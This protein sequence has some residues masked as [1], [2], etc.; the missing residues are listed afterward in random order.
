MVEQKW[1]ALSNTTLGQLVAT[2]NTS[3]II[4]ALPPVFRGIH[5]NP[6][7]PDSFPY[8]LWIIMS[9]MIVVSV[10]LLTIG[11]L[12]DIFGRVRLFNLGFLIFTMGSILLYLT[13]NTADIGALEIILF[14]II[15][16]VGGSFIMANSFAL[17]TDNFKES[18]RGFA[19]S[20]NSLASV[21]G[22]S[23]GIVVGGV[24]SVIYWRD[25][26]LLSVPLGIFGTAWSYLKLK[27]TSPRKKQKIDVLGNVLMAAG[28]ISLLIGVTYGITPYK[29]SPMGWTN[30]MV[31]LALIIGTLLI[32]FFI[33]WEGRIESPM[34][35]I[36]LFRNRTFAIG[37]FTAFI[38]AMGMMGLLYMLT[39]L[40]Q[41]V[42]LPLH[43]YSFSITPLWAGIYMLP[44]TV[45]MGIFGIIAG[46]LADR[47]GAKWLV[48]FGLLLSGV[49]LFILS[50]LSYNFLYYKMMILLILFGIGYA[51]FNSPNI[52][53]VMSTVPP[54]ER[55]SASGTL[56]NMR[57]TGYVASMGIFFSILIAGISTTLPSAITS[58][59]N[60]AGASSLDK[61]V[62]NMPPTVAI[63]GSF[64]GI[65]PIPSFIPNGINLPASTISI[66][67]GNTWF[68]E[69]FSGPFMSSLDV[70]L[71]F[72]SGITI[73]AALISILRKDR[74]YEDSLETIA[75]TKKESEN[76]SNKLDN[77]GKL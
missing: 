31:I 4:V 18:E 35:N 72:A 61:T 32:V 42:W 7:L 5:L 3:I 75:R 25:I 59:L 69:V 30:P 40:F 21:S 8:L 63:F 67:E 22:V 52:A 74:R 53:S 41:G 76:N 1:I 12:S 2:I 11:K 13:P 45:T 49:S 17:I 54:Q 10:L 19:I 48:I 36:H 23:I 46:R 34:L 62:S 29:Q 6:L 28:L 70:V 33:L 43:G 66:I 44:L 39:L 68:S 60:S 58:A 15:Q 50:F 24:L 64:L 56:N 16:A 57:N 27:E 47:S 37:S 20:I 73:I 65:N 9:Y 71:F 26:F 55:G 14:R 51:F 77:H 38:S